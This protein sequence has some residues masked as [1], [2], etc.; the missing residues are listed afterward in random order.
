[1]MGPLESIVTLISVF[2]G[3]SFVTRWVTRRGAQKR[4]EARAE[5]ESAGARVEQ[6]AIDFDLVG[7][8]NASLDGLLKTVETLTAR[9][10]ASESRSSRA[11][12]EAEVAR[13][14]AEEAEIR[15]AHNEMRVQHM[16]MRLARCIQAA[17]EQGLHLPGLEDDVA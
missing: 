4:A 5:R 9:L 11:L 14:R 10:E 13:S 8:A 17:R 16:E 7:R 2:V 6:G 1:M 3:G 12:A 15:A